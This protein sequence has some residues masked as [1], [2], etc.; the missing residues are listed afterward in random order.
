M[1][2]RDKL[3]DPRWQNK[4]LEILERD[5]FRCKWCHDDK[6][7]LH[8]HHLAYVKD[9]EPWDYPENYLITLCEWCHE[10]ESIG[11]KPYGNELLDTLSLMGFKPDE[12]KMLNSYVEYNADKLKADVREWEDRILTEAIENGE[13]E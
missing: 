13:K 7:T 9:Y 12:I 4:R 10:Y 2:Y 8:V 5:H 3:K 11:R 1:T 6:K